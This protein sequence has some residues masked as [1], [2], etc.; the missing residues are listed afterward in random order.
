MAEIKKTVSGG[1]FDSTEI[2]ETADGYPRGNK[3]VDSSFFA[4]MISCFY[5]DGVWG[6]DSFIPSA[7]GGLNLKMSSGIAWIRGYMAWQKADTTFTLTA[8]EIYTVVLRL[9]TMEGEFSL[10]AVSDADYAPENSEYTKDLVLAVVTVPSTAEALTANMISDKRGDPD[11]CGYV[12]SV[13]D[14][15]ATVDAAQNANMLGGLPPEDYL[16]RIGGTMTGDLR[17]KSDGSGMSVVR[18]IA[19]GTTLPDTMVDGDLFIL[20]S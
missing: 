7:G 15:L 8:G 2:V 17:A 4:K 14:A 20:L 12:T 19:Y 6:G 10:L 18:N 1:M 16:K 3:A 11:L 13:V 5:K 9:D